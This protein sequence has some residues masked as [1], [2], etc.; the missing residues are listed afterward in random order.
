MQE[1]PTDY[2]TYIH[3]SRYARFRDDLGRRENWD[4][5][6]DRLI[7]FWRERFPDEEETLQE[8]RK[9]ILNLEIMPSMRSLMT[10]GTALERDHVAGYNCAFTVIDSP[11]AFDEIM[12]ILLCGTGVGFS[13]QSKY[14]NK[15]PEVAEEMHPTDTTIV[16]SDSKVGWASSF[17]ELVSLLYA[18]KVPNWDMSKVRPAGA[19]LKTFGGRASGP[20]PLEDLFNFT[21]SL[22]RHACGRKLTTL[23]C[24]DLVC[25]VAEIVVVGGVRRSALISLSD[26]SDDR[27]RHAKSGQWWVDHPQ[28]ALA[29]NSYVAEDK[30][31]FQT[32]LNEWQ[33]LYE[34]RS[35]E[36]GIFSL[37][38]AQHTAE[39][40]GR[41]DGSKV[42]GT[43]PCCFTG[44]M[45]LLTSDGYQKLEDLD[46]KEVTIINKDATLT[47]GKVWC[48]GEREVVSVNFNSRLNKDSIICTPDHV[49]ML[50]DGSEC[51]ADQLQGKRLMPFFNVRTEFRPNDEGI[52]AGF[53]LGDGALNRLNSKSHKG[54]EVYFGE[55]DG[56]VAALYGQEAGTRWYS[57]YAREVALRFGLPAAPIGY[58][59]YPAKAEN[60]NLLCGLFS[61]NGCVI[62]SG[63]RVSLKSIDRVQ[64]E[65]VKRVLGDMGIESYITTNKPTKVKFE[66]GE[67]LC[68][69]SYD[70]NIANLDSLIEFASKI[71]F[72]Q[73]YKQDKLR[74][75]I[76]NKA[77]YVESVKEC[78]KELVYDFTEPETH[79]G[80]VEGVVVHNSEILLRDKQ[81]CNLTEVVI[82]PDDTA[83]SLKRKVRL[84]TILG[85]W[86]STLT[87]FRYLRKKWRD[88]CE[89]ER[90]LGVSLTGIC[91]HKGM[92][93]QF[94][95]PDQCDPLGI[96]TKE[97]L[98]KLKEVA[99]ETNKRCAEGLGIAQSAAITCVKPSGT[100][101][102]LVDSSSGIHPRFSPYYVRRVRNDKKD[103]LS[104]FLIDQG[105]PYEEDVM[106]NQTFVFSFPMK[107]PEGADIAGEV[108]G[109]QQLELWKT[110]AEHWCEHKPSMTAYYRDNDFLEMGNWIWNNFDEVSGVSFLPHSDHTYQQ[111]PYEEISKEEYEELLNKMP[112]GVDWNMLT[113]YESDDNTTGSQELACKGGSCE[114][115]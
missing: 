115:S 63:N 74:Q 70:L 76:L 95:K 87:D 81:F 55:N 17:R 23:E 57:R 48:S 93:G 62:E 8:I 107:S 100:V 24:H 89:E 46:E 14:T 1:L 16:V 39:R 27:M 13:V 90:L 26:L 84:A 30:P 18:G 60:R 47:S 20:E 49:F 29:N 42:V 3:K 77:P 6:V 82:R 38:A 92:T 110:Y 96:P 106:N 105:F 34:S 22:F 19:R 56:D 58:R 2:Q 50:T 85:T 66:N 5:T 102:Q 15:L 104:Q 86:Q 28:R 9:A 114:I 91:D 43:N 54:L 31:D 59:G 40:N 73:K 71:S 108:T 53:M 37:P 12:Y 75:I 69:Q 32:F 51:R 80:I 98:N 7:S 111:A 97:V 41:R 25:K 61:A 67:Y 21:V 65:E 36:R 68:K 83:T 33:S 78:G 11:R 44:E 45:K 35:G 112:P 64:I 109:M 101:S 94:E 113:L 72:V 88:N 10:A 52:L 99:I 103:P 79:W 4:E